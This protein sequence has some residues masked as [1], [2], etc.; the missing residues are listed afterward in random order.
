MAGWKLKTEFDQA[1]SEAFSGRMLDTLNK[2]GLS[3]M[4]SIGHRTGLFDVM[5]NLDGSSS[6]E[7]A[8]AAGLDERYVREWL[9]AMVTGG[10]V[11]MDSA[12]TRFWLPEEHSAWL[13]RAAGANNMALGMQFVGVLG[14]V[15]DDVV[16]CFRNGGGVPYSR[17]PRFH[18]VM[19]EESSQTVLGVID[20]HVLPMVPG[21][22]ERLEAGISV[23]DLG[24]G[25]GRVLA[26]LAEQFPNSR[27]VGMDLSQEAIDHATAHAAERGLRNVKFIVKDL[28]D[29]DQTP[30]IE[31][32]DLV[33]TFDAVHDQPKPMNLLRG[34]HK[35]LK[36]GG[37]YLMQDIC[38]SCHIHRN[39]EHPIAP[40]LYTISCMHCMTVSLAQ[41]GDGLGAMWGE[42]TAIEY[43]KQVGF[44]EV[45][46]RKPDY[47]I[48]NN[49][50]ISRK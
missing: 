41:G 2:A 5:R 50:Y 27:F 34:I 8:E 45:E 22:R 37:T 3:L 39:M 1:K 32:F 18:A 14:G 38:G 9:G 48:I 4:I 21:L 23:L 10:I 7:L 49:W 20:D 26:Y 11:E 16:E 24:C 28:R 19:A 31:A 36:P 25:R 6:P 33:T 30:T 46:K 40:W 44:A 15:E 12:T 29:F 35:V 17:Y 43:L 42:E 47:D 13:T